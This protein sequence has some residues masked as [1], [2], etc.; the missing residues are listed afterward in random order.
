MEMEDKI[1]QIV[2]PMEEVVEYKAVEKGLQA[3]G[4]S[5]GYVLV[6]MIIERRFV[7]CG[8]Q[9]G[10]GVTRLREQRGQTRVPPVVKTSTETVGKTRNVFFNR[11]PVR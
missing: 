6:E 7:V 5:Q 2:V 9:H 8:S 11:A 4:L 1:F 10:P 3:Q